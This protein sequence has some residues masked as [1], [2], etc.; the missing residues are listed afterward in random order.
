MYFYSNNLLGPIPKP[1][2][3]DNRGSFVVAL[4]LVASSA[5][6]GLSL[7]PPSGRDFA[8][9]PAFLIHLAARL[10]PVRRPLS[11]GPCAIFCHSGRA[12]PGLAAGRRHWSPLAGIAAGKIAISLGV[13]AVALL[14]LNWGFEL[15]RDADKIA[16]LLA[17]GG[18]QTYFPY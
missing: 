9:S 15:S 17:P 2:L 16:A 6:L 8:L 7:T 11:P 13:L 3:L 5:A 18:N 1:P 12:E 4:F 14:F 10:D